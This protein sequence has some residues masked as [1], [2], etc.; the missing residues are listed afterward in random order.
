MHG[1]L[2]LVAEDL[3]LALGTSLLAVQS[4]WLLEF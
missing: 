2:A 3:Y 4:L 1:L